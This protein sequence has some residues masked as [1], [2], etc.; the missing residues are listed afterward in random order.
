MDNN[1]LLSKKQAEYHQNKRDE[2]QLKI[3][4]KSEMI[5]SFAIDYGIYFGESEK[6]DKL[7]REINHWKRPEIPNFREINNLTELNIEHDKHFKNTTQ[8][9]LKHMTSAV[10]NLA[11]HIKAEL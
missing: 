11:E 9:I 4:E 8:Y 6:F 1:N 5:D 7:M 10:G 3:I 2:S